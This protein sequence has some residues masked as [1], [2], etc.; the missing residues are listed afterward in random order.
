MAAPMKLTCKCPF[1]HKRDALYHHALREAWYEDRKYNRSEYKCVHC[2][3]L[4][5]RRTARTEDM[6]CR[7]TRV[8]QPTTKNP[9]DILADPLDKGYIVPRPEPKLPDAIVSPIG[10]RISV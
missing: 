3:I 10:R 7:T 8:T 5:T 1:C 4:V 6:R 9:R 2:G